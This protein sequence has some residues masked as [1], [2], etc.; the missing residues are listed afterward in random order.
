VRSIATA[1]PAR[2]LLIIYT[3]KRGSYDNFIHTR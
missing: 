1:A 2:E 3:E